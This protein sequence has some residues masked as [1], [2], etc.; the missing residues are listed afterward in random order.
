[1]RWC[2]RS[3][4]RGHLVYGLFWRLWGSRMCVMLLLWCLYGERVNVHQ[5]NHV[6][7]VEVNRDWYKQYMRRISV[8]KPQKICDICCAVLCCT[9]VML[10]T[11]AVY[12]MQS[13]TR[14][15]CFVYSSNAGI[16]SVGSRAVGLLVRFGFETDRTVLFRVFSTY[17]STNDSLI[18]SPE[19]SRYNG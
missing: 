16:L 17:V 1:M 18:P 8:E 6:I 9:V 4:P 11:Y 14:W 2:T 3:R 13:A 10:Y 19:W 15:R 12:A 7:F 5:R